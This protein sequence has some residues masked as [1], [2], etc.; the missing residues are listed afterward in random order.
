[1]TFACSV[2]NRKWFLFSFILILLP[3]SLNWFNLVLILSISSSFD[4]K[5]L[6]YNDWNDFFQAPTQIRSNFEFVISM[7][8]VNSNDE[9]PRVFAVNVLMELYK[10]TLIC[11][12]VWVTGR[13]R[14]RNPLTLN[15]VLYNAEPKYAGLI[16][17]IITWWR[18]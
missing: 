18:H 12:N 16:L 2:P 8:I 17:L 1:M 5:H 9:M 10:V 13:Q 4:T 11:L 15:N 14:S 6:T 3:R 7:M